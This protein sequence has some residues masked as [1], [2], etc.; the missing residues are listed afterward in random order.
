MLRIQSIRRLR[1]AA[2]FCSVAAL[3]ACVPSARAPQPV[4]PVSR[5]PVPRPAPAPPVPT[6]VDRA[7][8]RPAAGLVSEINALWRG[9]PGTTG[10]AVRRIDGDWSFGERKD[11]LFPQQSVSKTWVTL[12]ILDQIDQGKLRLSDPVTITVA[13]LAVFHQPIRDR[14]IANGEITETV[15][16]LIEQAITKSDNTA[17]DALLW[18]AGGPDAARA[19]GSGRRNPRAGLQR[20]A[21]LFFR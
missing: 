17:N 7:S 1:A 18:K 19:R 6:Y 12:T 2:V 16:S 10:I 13:D 20:A 14:V 11:E 4:P 5:A 9:F 21:E 15:G 3:S 8:E